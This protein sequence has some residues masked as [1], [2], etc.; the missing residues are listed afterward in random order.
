MDFV[1]IQEAIKSSFRDS[2]LD[3]LTGRSKFIW[4]WEPASGASGGLRMGV[5]EEKFE[6]ETCNTSKY[7]TRMIIMDKIDGFKWN[8]VNVYGAAN[9]KDKGAF[10]TKFVQMLGSNNLPFVIGGDF[11]IIR[12]SSERNKKKRLTKWTFY[13]NAI[14]EHWA[15]KELELSGRSFTWSN[16]QKDPLFENLDRILVSHVWE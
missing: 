6:V 10:L 7:M 9:Y 2:S 12:K 1:C 15:L 16:N 5:K 8:L 13:F 14:I 3:G 11:S 4:C